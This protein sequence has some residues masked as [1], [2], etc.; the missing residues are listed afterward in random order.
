MRFN[1]NRCSALVRHFWIQVAIALS[2]HFEHISG[3]WR[4][5]FWLPRALGIVFRTQLRK[6]RPSS[7]SGAEAL[8]SKE[9]QVGGI[10]VT[11]IN[12]ARRVDRR[13]ETEKELQAIG[14]RNLRRF[15]AIESSDGPLGCARSHAAVLRE[16]NSSSYPLLVCEDDI[17]FLAD[18]NRL[19]K[20]IIEFL[21]NSE[22]DVLCLAYRLRGPKVKVS[23]ELAI[24]NNV[25]TTACYVVK[26]SAAQALMRS[27]QESASLLSQGVPAAKAAIDIHW[28]KYQARELVFCV[29]T[30]PVARQRVSYSDIAGKV[31]DYG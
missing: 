31:K 7:V 28:K 9:F 14:L 3:F 26:V 22:L 17:D 2:G 19:S 10:P 18:S 1:R 4:F 20:V 8:S 5:F 27:F 12:L 13:L 6:R 24:A 29:P 30:P 25:Q 21:A 16:T 15:S 11:Y 23:S